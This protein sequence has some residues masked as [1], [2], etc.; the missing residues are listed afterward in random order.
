MDRPLALKIMPGEAVEVHRVM[1]DPA[2]A[3]QLKPRAD[4][5]APAVVVTRQAAILPEMSVGMIDAANV[6]AVVDGDWDNAVLLVLPPALGEDEQPQEVSV[7][8]DAGFLSHVKQNAPGLAELAAKTLAAIRAAGVEGKLV[9]TK[10]GRW[11]NQPLNTFTLKAQP[12]A[13]N[14]HFTIYGNPETYDAGDF[15]RKDQNSYSRGWVR[16]ASDAGL[17]AKLAKQAHVRRNR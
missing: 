6:L 7:D 15:L 8:G 14:L 12:Q 5:V 13:G 10:L 1:V 16:N 17:L 4:R 11:V 3:R 2:Q 9:E